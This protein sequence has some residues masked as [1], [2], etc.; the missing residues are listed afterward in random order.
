MDE[1][2]ERVLGPGGSE[3][4]DTKT[5]ET[6]QP[7]SAATQMVEMAREKYHLGV[8]EAGEAFARPKSGLPRVFLLRGGQVSLRKQ[9][10]RTFFKEKGKAAGQQALSDALTTL[11]GFAQEKAPTRL[12][13]RVGQ[14]DGTIWIDLGDDTGRAIR[15]E[16]GAWNVDEPGVLFKRTPLTSALPYPA[17][18]GDLDE[19]W[20]FVNV[21]RDDRAPILA[22]L[23]AALLP[24]IPH[25]V[26]GIFGQQGSAKTSTMRVLVALVDPSPVPYRRPP[27]DADAWVTAA[28]G[29]W[30]VALDNLSSI[31]QWLADLLCRAVTGEGDVRRMLYTDGDL[32]VFALRR[33][34]AL[35]GIDLGSLPGDL[36]DRLLPITLDVIAEEDRRDE[37]SLWPAWEEAHPRILGALL[38][39][40]ANVLAR[41][42]RVHMQRMPRMADYARVL[43]AVDDVLGTD[44]LDRYLGAQGRLAHDTLSGDSFITSVMEAVTKTF[45]GTAADLLELA[46]PTDEKWR[47]PKGWPA[48]AR[49]ATQHL[50][51][52]APVLRKAGWH[53]SDDRGRN[54]QNATE[55]RLIPPTREAAA[56]SGSPSSP[57]S[58]ARLGRDRQGESPGESTGALPR[59]PRPSSPLPRLG[60]PVQDGTTSQASQ[61]SHDSTSP[62]ADRAR[63]VVAGLQRVDRDHLRQR[64]VEATEIIEPPN[65]WLELAKVEPIQVTAALELWAS[66]AA[67]GRAA[68]HP[69]HTYLDATR[70]VSEEAQQ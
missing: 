33:V 41:L 40:A 60:S 58:H 52:Q 26:L 25:P 16:S 24:D 59:L 70:A 44:G 27:R 47:K 46:T 3:D 17:R 61:A 2:K 68:S 28:A 31:Q 13:Q 67:S 19:L 18:D 12:Y 64:Y 5:D 36:A 23:V 14:R 56:D 34:I 11:D 10:A 53:V 38:D 30:V 69:E 7:K 55:W 39:L 22:Y 49:V 65:G 43:A 1:L 50:R 45:D 54:K 66:D 4:A 51:K 57:S 32:H 35:T 20:R 42:P 15:V 29:S 8:S 62:L 48:N 37:T 9:L 63:S 6:S 21:T